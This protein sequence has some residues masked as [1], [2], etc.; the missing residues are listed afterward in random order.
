MQKFVSIGLFYRPLAAK[1]PKFCGFWTFSFCGVANWQQSE[2]VEHECTTTY[3]PL[4]NGITIVSVLQ[5]L[6]GEIVRKIG[7][8]DIHK[9]DEL[10]NKQ[11]TQ[12]AARNLAW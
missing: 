1:N 4:S 2:E 6:L 9:R 11:K 12:R 5:R 8:S 7:L 3:L 10:A